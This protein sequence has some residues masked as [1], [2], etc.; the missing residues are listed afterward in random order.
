MSARRSRLAVLEMIILQVGIRRLCRRSGSRSDDRSADLLRPCARL[1][2][3]LSLLVTKT[4]PSLAG[5]W[6]AG[7][8]LGT[9]VIC[10]GFGIAR[11]GF[12]QAHP[13][14]GHDRQARVP[15]IA[16]NVDARRARRPGCR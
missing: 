5:V 7:T 12:D 15:A 8:S 6:Q 14:T 2:S 16:G 11:A 4:V 13:A 9:I 3:T 10:A 1:C